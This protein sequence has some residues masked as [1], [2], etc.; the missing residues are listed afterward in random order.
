MA[1]NEHQGLSESLNIE[2]LL[3]QQQAIHKGTINGN[4]TITLIDKELKL[5]ESLTLMRETVREGAA[6][7]SPLI[8]QSGPYAYGPSESEE[9]DEKGR[10]DGA[11][12]RKDLFHKY[13]GHVLARL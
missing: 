2:N 13:F 7:L 11:A 12:S 1:L 9:A 5:K 4:L 8:S 10:E 3:T 6:L